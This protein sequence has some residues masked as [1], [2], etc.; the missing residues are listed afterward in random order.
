MVSAVVDWVPSVAGDRALRHVVETLDQQIAALEAT[1]SDPSM[2]AQDI[3]D[4]KE[5]IAI[6]RSE[7]EKYGKIIES[8]ERAAAGAYDIADRLADSGAAAS[9]AS[10]S[11]RGTITS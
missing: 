2:T 7:R 10:I 5:A 4:T 3:A 8:G 11:A 1:L 9:I 6:A